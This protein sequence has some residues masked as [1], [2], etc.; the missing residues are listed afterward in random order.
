MSV[1]AVA[2]AMAKKPTGM[3][4]GYAHL[5]KQ[6]AYNLVN[7]QKVY[8]PAPKVSPASAQYRGLMTAAKKMGV[9]SY[10]PAAGSEYNYRVGPQISELQSELT[11]MQKNAARTQGETQAQYNALG[12][13]IGNVMGQIDKSAQATQGQIAGLGQNQLSQIQSSTPQYDG[14]LGSI[15]QNIANKETQMATDRA[16]AANTANQAYGLQTGLNRQALAGQTGLAAQLG[17]QDKIT[18]LKMQEAFNERPWASQ[19]SSLKSN[20][21]NAILDTAL[22]LANNA[23]NQSRANTVASARANQLNASAA[24]QLAAANGTGGHAPSSSGG[25]GGGGGGTGH[26]GGSSKTPY[27]STPSQQRS[28]ST[29]LDSGLRQFGS[30]KSQFG[31]MND[32]AGIQTIMH[33]NSRLS[34]IQAQIVLET[35]KYGQVRPST[36]RKAHSLGYGIGSIHG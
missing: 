16:N 11:G 8:Q 35:I 14:P 21:Y 6:G 33:G 10:I 13:N 31:K 12:A 32:A 30:L 2:A 25:S 9:D 20:K 26:S 23:S 3:P 19:L 18:N 17:G 24:N 7:G 15:A 4:T 22:S 1:Q 36:I 28:F 29:G 27:G 5:N 34:G